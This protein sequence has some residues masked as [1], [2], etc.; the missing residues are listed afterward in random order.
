MQDTN[1][2]RVPPAGRLASP[3]PTAR[4]SVASIDPLWYQQSREA[5]SFLIVPGIGDGGTAHWQ[6]HWRAILPKAHAL[7]PR[8]RDSIDLEEWAAAISRAATAMDRPLVIAHSFGCIAALIAAESGA[9]LG[10]ALLVAPVDVQ[11]VGISV[12]LARRRLAFPSVLVASTN[13]PW[14]KLVSAGE[15][16]SV[17][18]SRFVPLRDAGHI[19]AES[20][21]GPWPEGLQ[22]LREIAQGAE[23]A[24]AS[25]HAN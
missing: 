10:G 21:F 23:R 11:E 4:Q 14:L 2:G 17:L 9:D 1:C 5:R 22:L 6:N 12:R 24:R 3:P 20:G 25:A 18:G 8:R 15:L 16:A 19:N 7:L 13:D